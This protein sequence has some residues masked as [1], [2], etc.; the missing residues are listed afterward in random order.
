MRFTSRLARW[1]IA[2]VLLA[3]AFGSPQ[4][5]GADRFKRLVVFGDSLSDNGN[6]FALTGFPP[7]GTVR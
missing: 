2:A 4:A 3:A 6:L 1:I 5:A 7:A